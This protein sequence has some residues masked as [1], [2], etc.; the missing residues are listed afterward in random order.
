[1][2]QTSLKLVPEINKMKAFG[3]HRT[4][5]KVMDAISVSSSSASSAPSLG[6]T[7]ICKS[8]LDLQEMLDASSMCFLA[9]DAEGKIC[10]WSTQF[11]N[12][13]RYTKDEMCGSQF[14]DLLTHDVHGA[15]RD[16]IYAAQHLH[17]W[18]S[19]A[20]PLYTKDAHRKDVVL[21]AIP[22][23]LN[24][25]LYI[26]VQPTSLEESYPDWPSTEL[27]M[28]AFDVDA[29]N[30]ITMWNIHM[31]EFSGFA[32]DDVLGLSFFDL[33]GEDTFPDVQCMLSRSEEEAGP[34][35]CRIRFHTL[36]GIPKRVQLSAVAAVDIAGQVI[37]TSIVMKHMVE[38]G[39]SLTV[40]MLAEV[41]AS[42]S[43]DDLLSFTPGESDA[44]L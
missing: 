37:G 14:L 34:S 11:A 41:S 36:A 32:E 35:T 20:I 39:E 5:I 13:L 29:S 12:L 31:T 3:F 40:R 9:L 23:A 2:A 7:L 4:L 15:V 28:P 1:L 25:K 10:E 21:L 16:M 30:K 27:S 22:Y 6:A 33:F 19:T 26:V 43:V 42:D 44:E 17:H 8:Q 24:D 38:D 18:K